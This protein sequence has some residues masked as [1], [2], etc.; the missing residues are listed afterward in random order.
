MRDEPTASGR[1][2]NASRVLLVRF[3]QF[4]GC[5][6]VEHQLIAVMKLGEELGSFSADGLN[7]KSVLFIENRLLIDFQ[8]INYISGGQILQYFIDN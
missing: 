3:H 1:V 6:Q 7:K 4:R 5:A 8:Y 2:Q